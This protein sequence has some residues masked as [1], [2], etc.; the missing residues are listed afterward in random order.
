M[1]E[2]KHNFNLALVVI[3]GAITVLGIMPLAIYRFIEGQV[4]IGI[5]DVLIVGCIGT[6][7]FLALRTGRTEGPALF[8]ALTYSLGCV[9]VARLTGLSGLLWAFPVLVANFM[10]VRGLRALVISLF[11]IAALVLVDT[12]LDSVVQKTIFVVTS[13][14]VS[15][16]A[17]VFSSRAELQRVQL[18]TLALRDP[19][20]GA[21]NRRGMQ[22][23]LEI[24]MATSMRSGAPLGL[25]IFDL[26]H[27]KQ[28][29]DSFGHAS[30][31][32]VLVQI[33]NIVRR[34]TRPGDRFFR[35][36]GEEFGLLIPGAEPSSLFD[37]AEK[38]R[39]AV[40]NE[41]HCGG[42]AITISVGAT[43][44]CPGETA[45]NWQRR[46][47]AAMYRAKRHG[48][49]RS[50]VDQNLDEEELTPTAT[51]HKPPGGR[52][53]PQFTGTATPSRPGG[54]DLTHVRRALPVGQ[55]H[56][57]CRGPLR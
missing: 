27:F 29:N 24:A 36:G 35:L 8:L 22:A 55:Q 52:H 15:L 43:P 46:A 4:W 34:T 14:V 25:F 37:I 39:C 5:I 2:L 23:E 18:E 12:A 1:N 30:G 17:F 28:V 56:R 20:T 10:L 33:A 32:D 16:F 3:F 57:H 26:D 13:L 42:H 40:A 7:S 38:L 51:G 44:Y 6:G 47:D 49:N 19:L 11:T 31:D 50:V 54:S 53:A 48:R 9:A 41:V 21:S 45:G